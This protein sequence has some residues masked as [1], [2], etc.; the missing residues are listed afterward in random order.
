MILHCE[1]HDIRTPVSTAQDFET[2]LNGGCH[3]IC[4]DTLDCSH[5]CKSKCHATDRE[6]EFQFAC[7][8][9]CKR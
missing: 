4:G 9:M 5:V 7:R 6:H 2:V 3:L 8:V 1:K